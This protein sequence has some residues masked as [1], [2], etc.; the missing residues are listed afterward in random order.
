ML[1]GL[2]HSPRSP[3][4]CQGQPSATPQIIGRLTAHKPNT[5][6]HPHCHTEVY[7]YHHVLTNTTE[8]LLKKNYQ[9]LIKFKRQS[10][11]TWTIRSQNASMQVQTDTHSHAHTLVTH[12]TTPTTGPPQHTWMIEEKTKS[13]ELVA[14]HSEQLGKLIFR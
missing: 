3:P 11:S 7:L 6:L 14:P 9:Q 4:H 5:H 12:I 13:V 8:I 2:R 1:F 10:R